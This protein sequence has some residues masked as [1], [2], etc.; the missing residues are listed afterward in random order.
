MTIM[1]SRVNL[2]LSEAVPV[3]TAKQ[4]EKQKHKVVD[5]EKRLE[6]KFEVIGMAVNTLTD[7]FMV[8]R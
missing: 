3:G 5:R 7:S 6:K 2:I 1:L 4:T 8:V